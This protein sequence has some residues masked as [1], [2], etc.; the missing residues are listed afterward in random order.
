[1]TEIIKK[2]IEKKIFKE[3]TLIDAP[4]TKFH[5]GSPLIKN[6]TLRVYKTNSNS[7]VAD[8]EYEIEAEVP[9]LN[10][11]YRDILKIDGMEPQEL[12]AV[13]GLAPKTSRFKRKK[14]EDSVS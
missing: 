11:N 2:L 4:V 8:E 13:Y 1:M 5:M 6:K 7:C 12:A 9:M 14:N 3:G 10:I